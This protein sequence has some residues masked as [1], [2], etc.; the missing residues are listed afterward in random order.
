MIRFAAIFTLLLASATRAAETPLVEKVGAG[1]YLTALPPGA[2]G[3]KSEVTPDGK[4]PVPTNDWCSS[5]YW[6]KFSQPHY[7]HPLAME[8]KPEGLRI[9]YP[10]PGIKGTKEAIFA[11]MPQ[12]KADVIVSAA[13][14]PSADGKRVVRSTPTSVA[15]EWLKGDTAKMMAKYGHGSPF[16]NVYTGQGGGPVFRFAEK[17]TVWFGDAI[18]TELGLSI[19]GKPYAIFSM[20]NMKWEGLG[21]DTLIGRGIGAEE[22]AIVPLPDSKP[23]TL[24]LFRQYAL[25]RPDIFDVNWS[26]DPENGDVTTRFKISRPPYANFGQ[27]PKTML[28]ALY[29][30]QWR[31]VL[32]AKLT[33]QSYPSVR[34]PMKIAEVKDDVTTRVKY[35]GVLP[36]LPRVPGGADPARI[37][38]YIRKD[39][40]PEDNGIHDTY[41]DGKIMGRWACLIPIAEQYG[42]NAEAE[43]L[44][45]RLKTRLEDWL[46]A[47]DA[48]GKPKTKRVFAH[49]KTWGTLIG[50]PA[51]YGSDTELNDHHFHYGYFLRAAGEVAR[52]D[53]AWAKD[54][55]FGGMLKLIIRDI[56]SDKHDDPL[57]PYL[58]NFDPY[59]G[60]SWASG[61]A[62]FGDGN[63]QESSSE[64]M[65]AWYGMILLGQAVGDTKMRDLGVWLYTTEM[66][67][68]EDYWFNVHCDLFPPGYTASVVTMVWG[69]KGANGTWFSAEPEAVHGI[70]FLPVTGGSLYLGRYPD[71]VKK[72]WDAML[73]ELA[74]RPAKAKRGGSDAAPGELRQWRDI[75]LMYHALSDPADALKRFDAIAATL[76]PEDGN[77][78]ANTY[79]W[80][81]TLNALGQVDRGVTAD[82]PLTATFTKDGK[83]THV[84]Y[85]T[86]AEAAT[87]MKFSDG[88][89][90]EA[91]KEG[92]IVK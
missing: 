34:G 82:H 89:T 75:L 4:V 10:G 29:P 69:G 70:N 59:A 19:A 28:V 52:R 14:L 41:G 13:D 11:G 92:W 2:K 8:V 61:H 83:K 40:G 46:T 87:P 49:D 67:A 42:L 25:D 31:S 63:N 71:Y 64:A 91:G 58:R 32:E 48:S 51:G 84:V 72:N 86:A 1:S 57:F 16:V 15:I 39:I 55:R 85:R 21:T 53:P 45:K 33:G 7:A 23:E 62:R 38:E 24:P 88:V 90:I 65:N 26:W 12:G 37:A 9:F 50:Y 47:T 78:M 54:D 20:G 27:T 80:I 66:T 74:A 56:A 6:M 76:K 60:H 36:A 17:P 43:L 3:P 44:T 30:H 73:S 18:S 81:A 79:H 77:S 22:C 5:L 35:P 68:I